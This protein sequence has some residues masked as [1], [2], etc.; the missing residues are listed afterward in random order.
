MGVGVVWQVILLRQPTKTRGSAARRPLNHKEP[1][2]QTQD[3]STPS[4]PISVH[5]ILV[6][7]SSF[8]SLTSVLLGHSQE[9]VS[10]LIFWNVLLLPE[11]PIHGRL[12]SQLINMEL[13]SN[14]FSWT[15]EMASMDH[16]AQPQSLLCKPTGEPYTYQARSHGFQPKWPHFFTNRFRSFFETFEECPSFRTSYTLHAIH[17]TTGTNSVFSQIMTA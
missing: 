14:Q 5:P 16:M 8:M 11:C 10:K 15:T 3:Q 6:Q 9:L 17:C 12:T 1:A 4:D 2:P 7:V 13:N